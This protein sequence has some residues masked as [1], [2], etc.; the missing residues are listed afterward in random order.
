MLSIGLSFCGVVCL[1]IG[2]TGLLVLSNQDQPP[3]V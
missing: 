2:M 1:C 3:A